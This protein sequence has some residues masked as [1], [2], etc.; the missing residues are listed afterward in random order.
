MRKAI[1]KYLILIAFMISGCSADL[2]TKEI[3]SFD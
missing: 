2:K 1:L 3:N